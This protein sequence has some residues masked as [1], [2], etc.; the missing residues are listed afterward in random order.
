MICRELPYIEPLEAADRLRHVPG[1]AFLDSVGDDLTMGRYSF[2]G[3]SPFG[4]FTVENGRAHWNGGRLDGPPLTRLREILDRYEFEPDPDGPPLQ[5]GCIGHIAYDFGQS[6]E[7]LTPPEP[8]FPHCT[9]LRFGFYDVIFTFDRLDRRFRVYSSG[10]PD[11]EPA[12]AHRRMTEVMD[13]MNA[14]PAEA[15]PAVAVT[16]W[17]SNFTREKF[18]TAVEKIRDYIKKGDIYQANLT[19]RF[20]APLPDG[21]DSW[22]FYRNL[23]K[24]NPAPFSAYLQDA[25]AVFSSS[26]PERFISLHKQIVEARPIKGTCPR[27]ADPD[28]DHALGQSLLASEKDRAEN[29]MIV[30][31]LRN[32]ISR[33]CAPGS[34]EV[35]IL[36]GLESYASVHH[37]TSV[38]RGKMRTGL[39]PIDLVEA[40]FPGGSIT[41]APKIRA[42]DI[43]TELERVSR[44]VYCGSI[45]YIGFD[46]SMD[47]NIAIRTAIIGDG[48]AIVQSGGGITLLSDPTSEYTETLTKAERLFSAFARTP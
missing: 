36:C 14:A 6:L 33:V 21:F 8:A 47:L 35:P 40:C 9:D 29:V 48:L 42:M 10:L 44:G 4:E 17:K 20:H 7:R 12:R 3:V 27:A 30:D 34:V 37:L 19:Q 1:F 15:A 45:G 25:K 5:S 39:G 46:G 16:G 13:L 23:R 11:R 32:D 26:S 24:E 38:V 2:I 43:I 31:L 41:G 28:H 22:S 18:Q